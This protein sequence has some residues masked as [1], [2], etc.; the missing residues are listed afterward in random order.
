MGRSCLALVDAVAAAVVN[1]V[2]ILRPC[3]HC[4]GRRPRTGSSSRRRRGSAAG[5][6][7]A[8]SVAAVAEV[9]EVAVAR[10]AGFDTAGGFVPWWP[11][12]GCTAQPVVQVCLSLVAR[13]QQHFNSLHFIYREF[14]ESNFRFGEN[15]AA[16]SLFVLKKPDT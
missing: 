13:P 10:A 5:P 1:V 7:G 9:G 8:V 3:P 2:S 4:S 16:T 11:A 6:S 12:E 14:G 15:L